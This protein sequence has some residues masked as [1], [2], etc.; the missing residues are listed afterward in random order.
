[1]V[2]A[3]D[4]AHRVLVP[5]GI[6]VDMRPYGLKVPLEIVQDGVSECIGMADTSAGQPYDLAVDQTL[7]N[8]IA[9]DMFKRKSSEFFPSAFYWDAYQDFLE[10]LHGNWFSDLKVPAR[11]LRK[12]SMLFKKCHGSRLRVQ[13][14]IKLEVY[15]KQR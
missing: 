12:V 9:N 3:L 14:R 6:L 13:F 7:V 1:M 15:E 4:E 5:G 11:A 8:G 2:H 10:D